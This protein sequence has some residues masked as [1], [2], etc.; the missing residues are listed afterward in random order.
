MATIYFLQNSKIERYTTSSSFRFRVKGTE[1]YLE[2]D[3]Q[4]AF[5]LTNMIGSSNFYLDTNGK[6]IISSN[7]GITNKD[8][9]NRC[10]YYNKGIMNPDKVFLIK[11][12]TYASS[13]TN[14]LKISLPE[15]GVLLTFDSNTGYICWTTYTG[16]FKVDQRYYLT[17]DLAPKSTY[18]QF[19]P[20]ISK[21]L[22]F[23][24]A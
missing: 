16:L 24:K 23:E 5:R 21:A 13:N 11:N 12:Y 14:C 8:W 7:T 2:L 4:G 20:D 3:T 1:N 6:Y 18:L 22:V 15:D 19:S 10:L 9:R 17:G